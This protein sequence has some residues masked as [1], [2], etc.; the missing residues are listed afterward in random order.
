MPDDR[1]FYL[2]GHR[3]AAG[4]R[5]ENSMEGFRHALTLPIDAVEIDIRENDS[6]LWVFH[7]D[8]LDRLTD[9][10]GGFDDYEDLARVRLRNSEPVPTLRELLDLYWGKMPLNIEIK[11]IANPGLLLDLLAEYPAPGT[12]PGLPWIF[13]S[14]FVHA[15]LRELRQLDCPWPLAPLNETP[16]ENPAALIDEIRPRS[17]HFGDDHIDLS[18]VRDL[19]ETGIISLVYTVNDAERA[20]FLRANGVAGIFTDEPSR[21]SRAL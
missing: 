3:G 10:S 20:R 19:G 13:I 18:L 7:D 11:S 21:L 5:L 14:S 6:T 17:W 2:I 1:P 12:A 8:D 4:E 16:P 15:Y 9:R